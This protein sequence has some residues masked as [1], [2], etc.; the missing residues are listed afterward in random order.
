VS[1][2]ADGATTDKISVEDH[3]LAP[4][5]A[6]LLLDPPSTPAWPR[7]HQRLLDFTDVRIGEMDACGIERVLLSLTSPGIQAGTEPVAAVRDARRANDLLAEV[8]AG[9]PTRFAGMAAVAIQD[10]AAAADELERAVRDLGCR[11]VLINGYSD[12]PHGAGLYLDDDSCLPFWERV[13]AL[14][15]PVYLHPRNPLPG[16]QDSYAGHP[17]LLGSAWAFGVET[18]THALRL[19]TSGLFDRFPGLTVVL[20]HLGELLPAA[21]WRFDHRYEPAKCAV[22]LARRPAE[23]FQRNFVVTTSGYFAD[24]QLLHCLLSLGADRVLFASDYP[25]ESM[26]EAARWFDAAPISP[27]DRT[28]IGR[29]NAER[30]FRLA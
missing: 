22:T 24:H 20:G 28:K 29:T 1:P 17:E 10:P 5:L 2:D 9:T 4:E 26:A 6:H 13:A 11:A 21:I 27:A 30:L 18:A 25:F 3:F 23:Y 14:D 8:V 16:Q 12:T 19:I 7:I 15:V